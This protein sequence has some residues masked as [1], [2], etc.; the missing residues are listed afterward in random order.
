VEFARAQLS[1]A[2]DDPAR[3]IG[4]LGWIGNVQLSRSM[5]IQKQEIYRRVYARVRKVAEPFDSNLGV[6]DGSE[7]CKG[8]Q[9]MC[10][11]LGLAQRL[12]EPRLG[13]P[14]QDA[15]P[16]DEDVQFGKPIVQPHRIEPFE[17]TGPTTRAVAQE[18]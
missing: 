2:E 4:W 13:L 7:F 14:L 1:H 9:K 3:L 5:R 11:A 10:F 16:A 15:E 18:R 17:R 6:R 8:D 12:H